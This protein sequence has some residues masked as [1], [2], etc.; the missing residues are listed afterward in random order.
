ME[1]QPVIQY[2]RSFLAAAAVGA[3]LCIATFTLCGTVVVLYG[4]R[5][6]E[7]KTEGIANLVAA[8]I[9]GAPDFAESLPP[10]L[11]DALRDRRCPEYKDKLVIAARIASA[12]EGRAAGTPVLEIRNAGTRVVSLLSL[13]ITVL[14]EDGTPAR[15]WSPWAATPFAIEDDWPGPLMPGATRYLSAPWTLARG[16]APFGNAAVET[17]VTELRLW[18]PERGIKPETSA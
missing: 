1:M 10:V 15:C 11:S 13:R 7:A 5:I 3:S 8:A 9:K 2:R 17:E 4:M 12:A 6:V 16:N 14:G 18:E